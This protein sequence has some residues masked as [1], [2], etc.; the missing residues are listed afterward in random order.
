MQ[1]HR[2]HYGDIYFANE[3]QVDVITRERLYAVLLSYDASRSFFL[4]ER[5]SPKIKRRFNVD[6]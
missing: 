4:K 5:R 3:K 6:I 2:A 1:N